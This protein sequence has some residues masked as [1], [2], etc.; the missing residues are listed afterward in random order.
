MIAGWTRRNNDMGTIADSKA[1]AMLPAS[2]ASVGG[3]FQKIQCVTSIV[4]LAGAASV[5]CR[6]TAKLTV[7]F[8]GL[9]HRSSGETPKVLERLKIYGI[10]LPPAIF[11]EVVKVNL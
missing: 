6:I 5:S 9:V 8:G 4:P 1:T 7:S 10:E 3:T 11:D 2:C